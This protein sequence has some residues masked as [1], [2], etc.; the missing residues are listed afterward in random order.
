MLYFNY[1][2]A[3]DVQ[4]FYVS[5]VYIYILTNM[6]TQYWKIASVRYTIQHHEQ[7]AYLGNWNRREKRFLWYDECTTPSIPNSW[8][9][10]RGNS[11]VKRYSETIQERG[12]FH[13]TIFLFPDLSGRL[14][15]ILEFQSS[16]TWSWHS[17]ENCIL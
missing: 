9:R 15:R 10:R 8:L 11:F 1:I 2:V 6:S 3:Y 12:A 7:E 13:S 16:F 14:S 4:R 5:F 17:E